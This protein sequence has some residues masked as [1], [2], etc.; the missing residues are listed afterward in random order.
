MKMADNTA[1]M[2]SFQNNCEAINSNCVE[3][4]SNHAGDKSPSR[5][6]DNGDT[7]SKENHTLIAANVDR[8]SSD[9]QSKILLDNEHTSDKLLSAV[10]VV[11][12]EEEDDEIC[13][14]IDDTLTV[15]TT[16]LTGNGFKDH[17]EEILMNEN[18]EENND[19]GVSFKEDN[20]NSC[21]EVELE[22]ELLE[23]GEEFDE[24][25][26]VDE[27]DLTE[28][29]NEKQINED[30]PNQI[31][32]AMDVEE[33]EAIVEGNHVE[34][35]QM[36]DANEG[37]NDINGLIDNDGNEVEEIEA[38]NAGLQGR[39]HFKIHHRRWPLAL[40][41]ASKLKKRSIKW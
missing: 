32:N 16:E 27:N 22:N 15:S 4:P 28:Q 40:L 29:D 31:E 7:S 23:Y 36:N 19:S 3:V 34:E 9:K 1:V 5:K 21:N 2:L 35:T 14:P 11:P 6:T 30:G 20:G 24:T 13:Q 39:N 37:G 17:D 41:M 10:N 25:N 8:N 12:E 33:E 38:N 18:D 26:E